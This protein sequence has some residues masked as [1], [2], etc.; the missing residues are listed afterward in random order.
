MQNQ[1]AEGTLRKL[2]HSGEKMG[3][4]GKMVVSK[5]HFGGIWVVKV[6]T[7]LLRKISVPKGPEVEIKFWG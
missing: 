6:K 7:G 3:L 1:C 5:I 2:G 4:L